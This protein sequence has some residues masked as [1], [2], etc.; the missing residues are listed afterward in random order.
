MVTSLLQK[1][2]FRNRNSSGIGFFV[3]FTLVSYR[4]FTL[5]VESEYRR[6]ETKR[7]YVLIKINNNVFLTI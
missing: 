6:C 4:H 7:Q 1:F 3:M 2:P 5:H